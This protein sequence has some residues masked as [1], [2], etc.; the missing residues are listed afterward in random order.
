MS[1][2]KPNTYFMLLEF[3]KNFFDYFGI[4]YWERYLFHTNFE[5][6]NSL[7]FMH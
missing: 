5:S 1:T 6:W 4:L 7:K 2:I 3:S